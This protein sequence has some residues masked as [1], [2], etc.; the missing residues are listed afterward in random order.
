MNT[1]RLLVVRFCFLLFLK[2]TYSGFREF[3][4]VQ[5]INKLGRNL[6][7]QNW[8]SFK[9]DGRVT[10]TEFVTLWQSI[11]HGNQETAEAFFY[12][13]DLNDDN[14][15]DS[16][17]LSPLYNV[18]D[19]D[20]KLKKYWPIKLFDIQNPYFLSIS[21]RYGCVRCFGFRINIVC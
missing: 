2:K 1:Y 18:F 9:G 4:I 15:I 10:K 19:T 12:L 13:A 5:K 16:K 7:E 20:G 3:C 17:D 6:H 11:T 21:I 8:L 14:I